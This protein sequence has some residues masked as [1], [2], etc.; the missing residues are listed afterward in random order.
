MLRFGFDIAR[1]HGEPAGHF[2]DEPL[3][4][5]LGSE[6]GGDQCGYA[7]ATGAVLA[8]KGDDGHLRLLRLRARCGSA[9][10][11]RIGADVTLNRRPSRR[12]GPSRPVW[13]TRSWRAFREARTNA[14]A[15][16]AARPDGRTGDRPRSPRSPGR[17]RRHA[18][19]QARGSRRFREPRAEPAPGATKTRVAAPANSCPSVSAHPGA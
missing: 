3:V 19:A 4:D 5:D 1:L 17:A 7:R 12:Q 2:L 14:H 13:P 9:T 11:P 15:T 16:S 8:G 10:L 6:F 18:D